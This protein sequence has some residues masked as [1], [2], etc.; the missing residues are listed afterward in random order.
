VFLTKNFK[1]KNRHYVPNYFLNA[2][3]RNI[4]TQNI[5]D[6]TEIS[7]SMEANKCIPKTNYENVHSNVSYDFSKFDGSKKIKM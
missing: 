1:E 7:K 4:K 6:I 2:M 3:I 5:I